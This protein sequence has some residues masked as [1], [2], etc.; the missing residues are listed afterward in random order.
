M[1]FLNPFALI[2]LAAASIPVLLHLLNLRRLRTVEFSSLR[3]LVELQQTRVRKLKL[4]QI[5]LLILRTL[6]IVFAIIA[7]A[8]PTIPGSLPL[9]SSTSR[10]SVVILIDNSG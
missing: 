9:L 8:R 4:Q 7:I 10:S 2:G 5:L 6:L 3:F 1:N